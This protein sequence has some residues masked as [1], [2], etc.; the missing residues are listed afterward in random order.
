MKHS[1]CSWTNKF[2][3]FINYIYSLNYLCRTL[4]EITSK[5][6][7]R[8]TSSGSKSEKERGRERV[9]D[10]VTILS[11]LNER[12]NARLA[13]V[14]PTLSEERVKSMHGNWL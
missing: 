12:D 2:V 1:I 9:R 5:S 4:K 7:N 11:Y 8:E 10:L 6:F 3:T 13:G 14:G